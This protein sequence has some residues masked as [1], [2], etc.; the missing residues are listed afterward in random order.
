MRVVWRSTR[1]AAGT[2]TGG[3]IFPVHW[4]E[5]PS[6]LMWAQSSSC[7]PQFL[8]QGQGACK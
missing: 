5:A 8:G 7:G 4:L 3:S 6:L 1:P 2:P